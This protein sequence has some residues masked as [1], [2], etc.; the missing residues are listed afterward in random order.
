ML[1]LFLRPQIRQWHVAIDVGHGPAYRTRQGQ[2]WQRCPNLEGR[3]PHPLK[4]L[5]IRQVGCRRDLVLQVVVLGILA[6]TPTTSNVS[7]G[8]RFPAS[9]PGFPP[10][11][12]GFSPGLPK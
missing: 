5:Q 9:A 1:L 6:D 8:S 3:P 7:F 4:I 11:A 12:S 2:R 10:D